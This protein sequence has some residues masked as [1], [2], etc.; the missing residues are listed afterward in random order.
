[1]RA[2]LA[3]LHFEGR[4]THFVATGREGRILLTTL[5]FSPHPGS[6]SHLN[7]TPERCYL[8]EARL[9]VLTMQTWPHFCLCYLEL[10]IRLGL[11][12]QAEDICLLDGLLLFYK[13][14]HERA[15][16]TLQFCFPQEGKNGAYSAKMLEEYKTAARG[17]NSINHCLTIA[18]HIYLVSLS[19]CTRCCLLPHS[20]SISLPQSNTM[21]TC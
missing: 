16:W 7:L 11:W 1:M 5:S 6:S 15:L 19:L 21:P 13:L 18:F 8:S 14:R 9:T 3:S 12:D 2:G 10:G 20:G 17:T 4:I